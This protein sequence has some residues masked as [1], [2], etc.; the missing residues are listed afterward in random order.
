ML[1]K[2]FGPMRHEVIC[3]WRKL[4]KDELCDLYS[5][6]NIIPLIKSRRKRWRG[7]VARARRGAYWF[8]MGRTEGKKSLGRP[9]RRR[10]AN[11]K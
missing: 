10:E 9:R 8:L 4:Y 2:L 7:H 5:S 6:P 1:R 3:E 11:I